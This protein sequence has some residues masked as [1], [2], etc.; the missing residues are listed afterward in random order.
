M[1]KLTTLNETALKELMVSI[2]RNAKDSACIGNFE[3]LLTE[4][5]DPEFVNTVVFSMFNFLTET[6]ELFQVVDRI[7]QKK[8]QA[9]MLT[10]E[11]LDPLRFFGRV[12]RM[13]DNSMKVRA[14]IE[15]VEGGAISPIVVNTD[16]KPLESM[17]D[18]EKSIL[19]NDA[20]QF[21]RVVE[22]KSGPQEFLDKKSY[23]EICQSGLPKEKS[24]ELC[25]LARRE[26]LVWN[27]IP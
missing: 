18:R 2:R 3:L 16:R 25:E 23:E 15:S 20:F 6:F 12:R 22:T 24:Q 10:Q 13:A 27:Y 26:M 1:S 5:P 19:L 8:Y 11:F 9:R 4:I 7:P 17:T 21:K 14:A